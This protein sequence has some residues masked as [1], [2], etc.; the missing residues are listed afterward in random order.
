[1]IEHRIGLVS[2]R[3]EQRLVHTFEGLSAL[4]DLSTDD[5]VNTLTLLIVKRYLL[6][7]YISILNREVVGINFLKAHQDFL[8]HLLL[9]LKQQVLP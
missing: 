6:L 2:I 8:L 4:V 5:I 3:Y 7:G 9:Y 1:M